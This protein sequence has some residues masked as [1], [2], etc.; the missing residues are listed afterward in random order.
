MS[1][2]V[3]VNDKII[4]KAGQQV[5][6]GDEIVVL[7]SINPYVSRGGLKLA[8]AL[9]L[10]AIDPLNSICMDI[11][12]STGGFSDCLLKH[13]AAKVYAIDVGY[14][15]LA[16]SL[17]NDPRVVNI[18]R[19]NFR[20]LSCEQIS[21]SIDLA[22]IDVSFISLLHILGNLN[23]YLCDNAA[24]IAL[25][26]PQFEAG[27]GSVGKNGVVRDAKVHKAVLTNLVE[28]AYALGYQLYNLSWSPLK[29]AKGN[30]EFLSLWRQSSNI[31]AINYTSI[32]DIV[33]RA[34]GFFVSNLEVI[35]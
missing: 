35:S 24:I 9:Q 7:E 15:Q 3:R 29:G 6:Q 20:Y 33:E 19:Q 17:R 30:I 12:A 25:I 23:C 22:V 21:D 2:H 16:W 27:K 26:K 31:D 34:H 10:F 5:K 13:G 14:G 11:G 28:S 32:E 18:E 4:T 8:H 1:G